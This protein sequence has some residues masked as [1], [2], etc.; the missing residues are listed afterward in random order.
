MGHRNVGRDVLEFLLSDD[1]AVV[2]AVLTHSEPPDCGHLAH[3]SLQ[4]LASAAGVPVYQPTSLKD[5]RF[6]N[7]MDRLAPDLIICANYGLIAPPRMLSLPRQGAINLHGALLPE[8]RGRFGPIW[9]LVNGEEVT[10][11]TLHFMAPEV[12]AGDII[13]RI[14]IPLRKADTGYSLYTRVS[15]AGVR[16]FKETWPFIAA[17]SAPRR[18]QPRLGPYF[19]AMTDAQ[20]R[21]DWTQRAA[22]ID[23][24]IR[25]CFFPPYPSA[26]TAFKGK[27]INVLRAAPLP[28]PAGAPPGTIVALEDD[29][30]VVAAADEALRLEESDLFAPEAQVGER[31]S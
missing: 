16:L 1:R 18:P 13:A 15:A 17:G 11:A 19:S 9:A 8:Y 28:R 14:E 3:P 23:R 6:V 24:L 20:R 30:P 27:R 4:D 21:I 10:G 2:A 29:R 25:A 7:Q 22:Q 12:D 26:H 31:L 5:D